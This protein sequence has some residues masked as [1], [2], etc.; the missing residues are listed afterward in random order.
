[1]GFTRVCCRWGAEQRGQSSVSAGCQLLPGARARLSVV[2][3]QF[4]NTLPTHSQVAAELRKR[5]GNTHSTAVRG[6]MPC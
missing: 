6:H 4:V 3:C 5:A 1:M 2:N